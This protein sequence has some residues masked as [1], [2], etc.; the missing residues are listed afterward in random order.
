MLMQIERFDI[1]AVRRQVGTKDYARGEACFREGRVTI[2]ELD[3][4][5]ISAHVEGTTTYT[6]EVRQ[7]IEAMEGH[8]TCPR[9]AD[10]GFCKHMVATALASND[11]LDE[12]DDSRS[13][14]KPGVASR[15]R[16]HL[17]T[18]GVD[19]LVDLVMDLAKRDPA[20]L[21][22]LEIAATTA[23]ADDPTIEKRLRKAID[24][25]T[26]VDLHDA[27]ESEQQWVDGVSAVLDMIED[28]ASTRPALALRLIDHSLERIADCLG[29]LDDSS[30]GG[31]GL[32]ARAG[33]LHVVVTRL[34]R[35]DPVQLAH[36]LFEREIEDEWSTFTDAA[37]RY[38]DVLGP[39]GLQAHHALA[40]AAWAKLP[41]L[42][43]GKAFD[44]E[45][46][47]YYS[48]LQGM[49]DVVA[50]RAGDVDARIALRTK[51]LT[52][53][54]R[55]TRLIGFCLGLGHEAEALRWA[56]EGLFEFE[57]GRPD[58]R[59]VAAAVD[60]FD[61]AGRKPEAIDLLRRTFA[62]SPS[63]DLYKTIRKIGGTD[64]ARAARDLLANR[65]QANR[66]ST[67]RGLNEI[68]ISILS[69][70]EMYAEAWEV[71]RRT[72]AS[73]LT[74]M[75]LAKVSEATHPAE[76][77]ETYRAEV[78]YLVATSA[79]AGAVALVGRMATLQSVAD[80]A[81][82]VADL[83]QRHSRKRNLMKLLV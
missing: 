37:T 25:A 24:K 9:Y 27:Y 34:A 81:A 56:E 50:K 28:L 19:A 71:A 59:R 23:N 66:V 58:E 43:P 62:K 36:N 6:L 65:L 67:W 35:P 26:R 44:P 75:D 54:H 63:L 60:L 80:H 7:G 49:L 8:C 29:S 55:Y 61:R 74:Q 17:A 12:V 33:E 39:E 52:T 83:K 1:D 82:V 48:T 53:P 4:C 41:P 64:A 15:I 22:R 73:R 69:H 45:R 2:I 57:D 68:M 13:A 21:D 40:E 30:G 20:L 16:A 18:R 46:E 11:I 32:L 76:A 3:P 31:H 38:A 14:A 42:S 5:G 77:I 51:T 10:V 70:E 72:S 47:L 79:Y 78:E